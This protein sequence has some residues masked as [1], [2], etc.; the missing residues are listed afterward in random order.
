MTSRET[1]NDWDLL[2]NHKMEPIFST[3]AQSLFRGMY[4]LTTELTPQATVGLLLLLSLILSFSA[5]SLVSSSWRLDQLQPRFHY[6][7]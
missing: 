4:S 6:Y 3:Y 5:S 1:Q 2:S 7:P